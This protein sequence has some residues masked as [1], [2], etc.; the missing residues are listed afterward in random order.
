MT[1]STSDAAV[2]CSRA[3]FSSRISRAISPCSLAAEEVSAGRLLRRAAALQLWRIWASCFERCAA[4]LGAPLHWLPRGLGSILSGLGRTPE[5]ALA[6]ST[7]GVTARATIFRERTL[8]Q[9]RKR[10]AS[11]KRR[12]TRAR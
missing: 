9:R 7:D 12:Q 2:C 11:P 5:V 3:S 6:R 8:S 4:D 1:W 10:C